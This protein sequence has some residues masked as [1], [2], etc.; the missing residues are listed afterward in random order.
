[1]LFTNF[2]E[3]EFSEVHGYKRALVWAPWLPF[4]PPTNLTRSV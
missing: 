1:V 3:C 2:V 4:A